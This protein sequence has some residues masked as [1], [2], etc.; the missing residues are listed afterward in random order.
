MDE[1]LLDEAYEGVQSFIEREIETDDK[2]D[3]VPLKYEND[4]QSVNNIDLLE[5]E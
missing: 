2:D 3:E 4:E 5:E 1:Q